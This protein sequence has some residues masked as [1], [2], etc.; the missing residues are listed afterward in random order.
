MAGTFPKTSAN[1]TSHILELDGV[2]GVAI[3]LVVLYHY[4]YVPSLAAPGSF[5][6]HLSAPLRIG[7]TGVDLFFVLSGFL[8]GGI[9]LDARGSSNYF[10]TFYIRRF[11]RI[12][13][14]YALVLAGSF[15]FVLLLE[16]GVWPQFQ[17]MMAN[18]LPWASYVFYLQNF[19]MPVK[20]SFGFAF[21]GGT[22]S[23]AVEE[24]FYLTL[25]LLIWLLEPRQLR[26][27]IL[28]AIVAAPLLRTALFV[29]RPDN[30]FF[31]YV[32]L[33]CRADALFL[34]VLAAMAIRDPAGRRWLES[35][36][37]LLAS[38]IALLLLGC[39]LLVHFGSSVESV[40]MQTF[41]YSWMALLYAVVI[42][43][44]L[45][46]KS[47]WLSRCFRFHPLR[48]LGRIA[49]GVYLFHSIA[50]MVLAGWLLPNHP[51]RSGWPALNSLPYLGFTLVVLIVTLAFCELSWHFFEKP[52]VQFG[53]RWKYE[54]NL[55]PLPPV[56]QTS[57]AA[58][59][60]QE[61]PVSN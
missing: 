30:Y 1:A 6:W 42:L 8:I 10:R 54:K 40:P 15:G 19:W 4:F 9:L 44:A 37:R 41:G 16:R 14:L 13:P 43:Y 47:S 5:V 52:L 17:W 51:I 24:Q 57:I 31:R 20:D 38:L 32:L 60:S 56:E 22:W 3:A 35:R 36:G 59:G 7:W 27:V 11:Y 29:W 33:P 2:R 46:Q 48:R 25:P 39:A 45:T 18:R 26:K 28:A 21:L 49:Y 58:S 61:F 50:I 23:L 53:H 55:A 34:G 12:V